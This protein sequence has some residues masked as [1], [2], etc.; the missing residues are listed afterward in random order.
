MDPRPFLL[1][2]PFVR[3]FAW[4]FVAALALLWFVPRLLEGN[5]RVPGQELLGRVVMAVRRGFVHVSLEAF[6]GQ[7]KSTTHNR[8][9]P[10]MR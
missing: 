4:R 1:S 5:G 8:V 9:K 6:V 3:G 2:T 10:A 7:S